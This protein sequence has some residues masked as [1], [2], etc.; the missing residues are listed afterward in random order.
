MKSKLTP[1]SICF[2][3]I[4]LF[5]F[6]NNSRSQA[7]LERPIFSK[8][9]GFYHEP[10]DLII[11]SEPV[12][13]TIYYTLDG[14]DPRTSITANSESAP[15]QI[16]ID[17]EIIAGRDVAPGVVIRACATQ[18]DSVFSPI[19]THSFLFLN[20]MKTLSLD[21]VPPGPGW[22]LPNNS[23]Y[24]FQF[25]DY[26]MDPDVMND[27]RYQDK[28]EP[29]LL[30]IPTISIVTDL[31]NLFNPDSGIYV[32]A[33]E[34]GKE[35]ER[36]ASIEL[37]NPDDSHGFQIDAGIRIRGGW[38]RNP[39]NPKHAFRLFFREAYGADKLRFAMFGD[40]G[41]DEF[42]K[43]DLRTGHNFSWSSMGDPACTMNRDVFSRD[44]Q[45]EM[46]QP[47][48]RS[49]Y[50][51]LYIN[52][53]YWGLYQSQERSEARF[54]ATY[55]GGSKEDYDVIK[56]AVPPEANYEIDVTD[57]NLF[58][59]Q[60]LWQACQTGF[61]TDASYFKAQGLN[62]DGTRNLE[63]KILLDIDNLIDYMLLIFQTAN[64]DAPTD[65]S[66]TRPNNFYAIYN[67]N[68]PNGFKFFAHD[69]EWTMLFFHDRT[70]L[71]SNKVDDNPKVTDSKG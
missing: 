65:L 55:F 2:I 37:I 64:L 33:Y 54:A 3:F 30:A 68:D 11:N 58:V 8:E 40:E 13:L 5:L 52:G 20:K 36:K 70:G 27:V 31:K 41:T 15:V 57:G 42:D 21:A 62:P 18:N 6:N 47:Y 71:N 32:H 25:M 4:F 46:G 44:T 38:F 56:I 9:R 48:T 59:W 49:R 16:H 69:N 26:G 67:R 17:P 60:E 63:Y 50:Y 43:L 45:R 19:A 10:F 29:A 53:T 66:G 12:G 7:S 34:R 24:G 51:H 22:P 14:T 1:I 23:D 39:I 61:S 28:I 35:W